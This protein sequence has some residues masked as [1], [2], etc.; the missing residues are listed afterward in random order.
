MTSAAAKQASPGR[1]L[2]GHEGRRIRVRGACQ[3]VGFRPW[4]FRTARRLG[5]GGAVRNVADGVCVEAFG[6]PAAIEALCDALR[7]EAPDGARIEEV[8]E[9]R[10]AP[11]GHG[12]FHI[13]PS[14]GRGPRRAALVP[15][16]PACAACLAEMHTP[17]DRRH[18][19]AL[20]T[21][22]G[23]GPRYTLAR[24]LPFDRA[25]T[26]MA[27]FP[28]CAACREEHADPR[29][30]RFHAQTLAC[31]ECGPRLLL[32][33]ASGAPWPGGEE[34]LG[35]TAARLAAGAVAAIKG[36]GGFHLACDATNARAVAR[37]RAAKRRD[38][39][40][41]AVMVADV[42]AAERLARLGPEERRLL[43]SAERP[44][45]L[46]PRRDARRDGLA[47]EVTGGSSLVGL[48]RPYTPVHHALVE[49]LGRPLVMTSA[50]PSGRPIARS[51]AEAQAALAGRVEL[52]LDHDRPIERRCDDS[53][54]RV[55][56]GR[57]TLLRR[58]RGF[59]P[60]PIRL[61]RPVREP[62]LACG[63]AWKNAFALVEGEDAWLSP[64][65]GDLEGVEACEA[66][67]E[68]VADLEA[69]LGIRPRRVAHDLHPAY[70]TTRYA[71]GRGLP[72]HPV[73]HHH[74]HAVSVMAEHGLEGAALALVWDGTGLGPDGT[75][76]GGE[77]L[78]VEA[79]RCERLATF[80][81]LPLPG[82]DRAIAEPWRTALAA[83]D[84][85]FDGTPPLEGLP[86]FGALDRE[87]LRAVRAVA[88]SP[89]L[90]PRA[91]GVGRLFDAV[92]ALVLDHGHARYEGEAALALEM[93]AGGDA[94]GEPYPWILGDAPPGAAREIDLRPALRAIVS[95]RLAGVDP[96]RIAAR[97]H[98]TLAEAAATALRAALA[99]RG[100]LPV[101]AAG[102]C[103]QNDLLVRGLRARLEPEIALWT[104]SRLPPGDG[105]L[106]LGQAVVAD[107]RAREEAS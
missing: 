104:A 10:I 56:G 82:A 61:A 27:D 77:L 94:Q 19:Y 57:P 66:F 106:A 101:L 51:Q 35:E 62:L 92:A 43:D 32:R 46:A 26:G 14:Q 44:V 99:A 13:V 84:E 42:A 24:S 107:A 73:A 83:V 98:A 41:F 76:W 23:C 2:E 89:R 64:H 16:R 40:P 85:A 79:A 5:L 4:V 97:F 55:V 75:A 59:A 60:R 29:S 63:G 50:N 15:D 90:A 8:V 48:M 53:V 70:Y 67:D 95:E 52:F 93:A 96:A 18:G 9:E 71:R 103:F 20:I 87:R 49:T 45:V 54:V 68:A 91:H 88:R 33:D 78:R 12:A 36:V 30:R 21:C 81:P 74:A 105:G 38:A 100:P 47:P 11:R 7:S 86:V 69:L 22:C 31:G 34:P 25:T 39:K 102:G 1:A 17:S 65:V 28:L 6:P 80:R 72:R 37:L 3:G 58:A